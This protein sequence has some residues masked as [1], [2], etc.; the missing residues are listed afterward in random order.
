MARVGESLPLHHT[1][2][3]RFRRQPWKLGFADATRGDLSRFKALV[4]AIV[5]ARALRKYWEGQTNVGILLPSTAAGALINMPKER[6]FEPVLETGAV[7]ERSSSLHASASLE[8]VLQSGS[9]IFLRMR[10]FIL[11]EV[12]CWTACVAMAS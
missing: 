1:F 7:W 12:Q 9:N 5:L 11:S 3:R 10:V 6:A 2:V 8:G 4:G